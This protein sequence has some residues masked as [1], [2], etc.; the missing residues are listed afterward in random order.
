V[1]LAA[2]QTVSRP[3]LADRSIAE[4]LLRLPDFD[5]R[6]RP[7]LLES[8][9]RYLQANVGTTRYFQ[10]LRQFDLQERSDE[11][12]DLALTR[13]GTTPGT[14]AAETLVTFG[15]RD[16]LERAMMSNNKV[17]SVAAV[18]ALAAI[19]DEDARTVLSRTLVNPELSA[20]A[21]N[22][23]ATV[24][25]R[26]P[27]GE[28]LLAETVAA[29]KLPLQVTFTAANLLH[30]SKNLAHR[31]IADRYLPLPQTKSGKP[32]PPLTLLVKRSGNTVKG[33]D[34]FFGKGECA[35]CHQVAKEGKVVGPDLTEIGSK[36]ARQ[37]LY[38]AV[39]DPN[40][41]ISHNYENHEVETLDGKIETGILLSHNDAQIEIRNAQ[42]VIRSFP[43]PQIE[44][45]RKLQISLMPGGIQEKLTAAELV[46]LI[47]YLCSLK[48]SP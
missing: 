5:L 47:E 6:S 24:L 42:G 31:A 46:D 22:A 23:I 10:L 39:L 34:I 8:L 1:V 11:L 19:G 20:E 38:S 44:S 36:L 32:L 12:L 21:L 15:K 17:R 35:T 13:Q 33:R 16:R 14:W 2:E 41:G 43:T 37:A 4:A 48:A 26:H 45:V 18:H 7:D 28:Q 9:D 25:A 30:V 29:G 40:A 3:P 27:K